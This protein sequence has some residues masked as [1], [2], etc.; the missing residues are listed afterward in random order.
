MTCTFESR[1]RTEDD[2]HSGR[3]RQQVQH[4]TRAWRKNVRQS[5]GV[6]D[7]GLLAC[8]ELVPAALTPYW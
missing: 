5:A 4:S 8:R 1:M 7:P 2:V 6:V 3:A